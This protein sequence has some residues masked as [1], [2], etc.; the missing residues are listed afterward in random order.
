MRNGLSLKRH[1]DWFVG[2]DWN[3]KISK[4]NR[5]HN[6]FGTQICNQ[7]LKKTSQFALGEVAVREF[8]KAQLDFT[9]DLVN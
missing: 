1:Y 5:I 9:S 7:G 3:L 8:G 4:H 2:G 6:F